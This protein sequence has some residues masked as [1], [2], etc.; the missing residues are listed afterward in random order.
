MY[1]AHFGLR[2]AP[3]R[4][5]PQTS[6]FFAGAQ[7]GALL[8][9]LAFA[10]EHDEGIIQV[11]GEVGVGKT[12]LCRM[13]LDRLPADVRTVYLANP[14]LGPQELLATLAHE[15]GV[16]TD[17]GPSLLRR[18]EEHLIQLYAEGGRALVII[19]EAHAMPRES[20]EQVRLLSNLESPQ[21]KLLQIALFGQPELDELL[22]EHSL[23][24]LRERITQRFNL[25][26]LKHDEVAAYLQFRLHAAGYRGP[27]LFPSDVLR[28]LC[29]AADGLTRRVNILADKT[30]LAAFADNT[31]NLQARHIQ[32]AISDAGYPAPDRAR[33]RLIWPALILMVA[34]GGGVLWHSQQ[35][36]SAPL[37][38][39][40]APPQTSAAS[41]P[42]LATQSA[43]TATVPAVQSEPA[44]TVSPTDTARLGER[45]ANRLAPSRAH[46]LTTPA[47]HWFI[48]LQ[49]VSPPDASALETYLER[50]GR[51][52]DP[53]QLYVYE[54]PL[55]G[56]S[57][58]GIYYGDFSSA[59]A[60]QTALQALPEWM[61]QAGAYLRRYSALQP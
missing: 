1:H 52:L 40:E 15:L 7:R 43:P 35:N 26:R 27:D 23:R 24:S 58:V 54:T 38:A 30:L 39:N 53:A 4:I 41:A 61:R 14:S 19:D 11:T 60:A 47:S 13:L 6:Y 12:M 28:P 56:G 37:P 46:A 48:Q 22:S 8:D 17:E 2:E 9:A 49:T 32:R 16:R 20:L 34:T 57:R 36:R 42:Q 29:H 5:T 18:I 33:Q 31:R 51:V 44:Q 59:T 3:F 50:V 55:A 21:R 45:A 25:D 10:I